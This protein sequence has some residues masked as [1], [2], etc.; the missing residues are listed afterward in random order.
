MQVISNIQVI[1]QERKAFSLYF[2]Y[3]FPL[4]NLPKR[5]R[6]V[7]SPC[8]LSSLKL[9]VF[10]FSSAVL[11]SVQESWKISYS[12]ES[13]KELAILRC[14]VKDLLASDSDIWFISAVSWAKSC[15]PMTQ[16]ST[17]PC[18]KRKYNCIITIN[19]KIF[20]ISYSTKILYKRLQF[21]M[22]KI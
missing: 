12:W 22:K 5:R 6:W 3:H 13:L 1:L 14:L 7:M 21:L 18:H 2:V 16:W 20:L 17:E 4:S 15:T 11:S 8:W 19:I 10:E 9:S